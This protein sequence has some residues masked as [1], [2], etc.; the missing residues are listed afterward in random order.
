[1]PTQFHGANIRVDD[2]RNVPVAS[3]GAGPH[4]EVSPGHIGEIHWHPNADEWQFY[5][6]LVRRAF[7]EALERERRGLTRQAT[8]NGPSFP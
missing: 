6:S 4:V 2:M 3:D 1:V 8:N 5:I 7:P